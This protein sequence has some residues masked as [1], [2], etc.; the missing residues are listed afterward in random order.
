MVRECFA[1]G[2]AFRV[3]SRQ[4]GYASCPNVL[5]GRSSGVEDELSVDGVRDLA[6]DGAMPSFL[7]LPSATL[8][9]K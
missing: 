7:L 2:P 9:S 3:Q 8:R 6:L 4:H 5:P 1:K